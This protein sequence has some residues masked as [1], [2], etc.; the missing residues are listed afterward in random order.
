[1]AAAF[2]LFYSS[3]KRRTSALISFADMARHALI[4][5]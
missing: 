2:P 4:A 3:K 1:M 5:N